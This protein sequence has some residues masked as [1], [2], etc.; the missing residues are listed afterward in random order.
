MPMF[1]QAMNGR[2]RTHHTQSSQSPKPGSHTH[3]FGL[4]CSTCCSLGFLITKHS[5]KAGNRCPHM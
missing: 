3:C 4:S 1:T 2:A 5:P